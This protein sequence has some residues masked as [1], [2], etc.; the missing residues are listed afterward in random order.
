MNGKSKIGMVLPNRMVVSIDLSNDESL[1]RT[2]AILKALYKTK[3]KI[4]ELFKGGNLRKI[5]S[6]PIKCTYQ[7]QRFDSMM[8]ETPEWPF[9]RP[10]L[11]TVIDDFILSTKIVDRYYLFQKKEWQVVENR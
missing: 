1:E 7:G 8:N 10:Q 11:N 4:I 3:K 6:S 2:E 5:D 9:C